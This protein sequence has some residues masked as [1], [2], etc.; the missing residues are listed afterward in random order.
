[1]MDDNAQTSSQLQRL[2]S[3][4]GRPHLIEMLHAQGHSKM[5]RRYL[6]KVL[7]ADLV[8]SHNCWGT[9]VT[10]FTNL[11]SSQHRWWLALLAR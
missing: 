7:R 5:H 11:A 9:D 10:F 8:A 1:M 2:A 6:D 3:S 4:S